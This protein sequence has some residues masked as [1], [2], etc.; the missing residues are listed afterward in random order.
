MQNAPI[1][2]FTALMRT[3]FVIISVFMSRANFWATFGPI[4]PKSIGSIGSIGQADQGWE[5]SIG[6]IGQG[7]L[8]DYRVTR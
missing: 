7:C 1:G 6:S 3:I 2:I 4:G 8:I 5:K